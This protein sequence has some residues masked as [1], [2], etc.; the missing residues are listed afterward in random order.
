MRV[1]RPVN[2]KADAGFIPRYAR[3]GD[4]INGGEDPLLAAGAAL[5]GA[6]WHPPEEQSYSSFLPKWS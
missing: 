6:G 3:L 1:R 4:L 5:E 2:L